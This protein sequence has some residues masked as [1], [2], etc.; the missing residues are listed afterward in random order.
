[1]KNIR[2]KLFFL[3]IA[4]LICNHSASAGEALFGKEI[5]TSQSYFAKTNIDAQLILSDRSFFAPR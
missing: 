1:M 2:K 3:L 4:S 5:K